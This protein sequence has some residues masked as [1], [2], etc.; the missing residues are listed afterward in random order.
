MG[1]MRGLITTLNKQRSHFVPV[2]APIVYVQRQ[3][4]TGVELGEIPPAQ[5]ASA[6][7]RALLDEMLDQG[8]ARLIGA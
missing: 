3:D 5:A 6:G 1:H 7:Y 4:F 8:Y 2:S